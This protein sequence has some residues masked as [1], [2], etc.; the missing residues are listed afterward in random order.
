[1]S[2][3]TGITREISQTTYNNTLTKQ[4]LSSEN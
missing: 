4:Y 3:D 2:K 1:M